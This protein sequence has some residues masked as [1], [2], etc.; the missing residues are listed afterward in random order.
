MLLVCRR[1]PGPSQ[2]LDLRPIESPPYPGDIKRVRFDPTACITNFQQAQRCAR[3]MLRLSGAGTPGGIRVEAN[4]MWDDLALAAA[5]LHTVR[6]Q[7]RLHVPHV[8]GFARSSKPV[9][10]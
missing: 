2:L 10:P 5:D 6:G 3:A 8:V 1:R 4:G 9:G 7:H